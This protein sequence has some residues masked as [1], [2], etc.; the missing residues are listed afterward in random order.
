[1][2]GAGKLRERVSIQSPPAVSDGAGGITGSWTT[3]ATVSAEVRPLNAGQQ[4]LAGAPQ[5]ETFYRVTLR[6][7]VAVTTADRLM[8]GSL[9]LTISGIIN[10]DMRGR[11]LELT[12]ESGLPS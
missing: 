1:M 10:P 6:G 5:G 12:C 8:W 11:W 9:A 4:L 3:T 7:G 2:A